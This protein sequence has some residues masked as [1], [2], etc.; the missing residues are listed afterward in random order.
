MCILRSRDWRLPNLLST[1]F[2]LRCRI[3]SLILTWTGLRRSARHEA[4]LVVWRAGHASSVGLK[5]VEYAFTQADS[6][7]DAVAGI[8]FQNY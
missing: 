5:N 2:N 6:P 8:R 3:D 1:N 7:K 4:I